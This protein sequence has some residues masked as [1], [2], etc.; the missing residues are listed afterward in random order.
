[1][2]TYQRIKESDFVDDVSDRATSLAKVLLSSIFFMA[3][4]VVRGY[5]RTAWLSSFWVVAALQMKEQVE[6]WVDDREPSPS[7]LMRVYLGSRVLLS[8]LGLWNT[9]E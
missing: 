6:R 5:L 9:T 4:S 3:L 7:H 8:V 1:M 2:K